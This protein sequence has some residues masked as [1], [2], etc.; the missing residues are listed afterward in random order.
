[1][2]LTEKF[3]PAQLTM[4]SWKLYEQCST[5]IGVILDNQ[6]RDP[7]I[8]VYEHVRH[9]PSEVFL[10]MEDLGGRANDLSVAYDG[11]ASEEQALVDTL[12]TAESTRRLN[13]V[14]DVGVGKTTFIKHLAALHLSTAEFCNTTPIYIDFSNFNAQLTDPIVD[15]RTKFIDTVNA[16]L[17]AMFGN[18]QMDAIDD[19]LFNSADIFSASRSIYRRLP[20][21][22]KSRF[23]AAEL[24]EATKFKGVALTIARI[25]ALCARDPNRLIIV[26]DNI[27]HLPEIVLRALSS[28]LLQIQLD[29]RPML[30]VCMRDHTFQAGFSSYREDKTVLAWNLRLKPPNL[31]MMLDRR[32]NHFFSE[33]KK[34]GRTLVTTGSGVLKIDR[35]LSKICRSLLRSPFSDQT[36]YEFI[37]RYTNYN[38]RDLFSN[39]QRIV[40]FAGFS[41]AEKE[42]LLQDEAKLK[43][44]VDECLIA[45]AL[46]DSLMFFPDRSSTFNP[47]SAG[48]DNHVLDKIVAGRV[49]QFLDYRIAAIPYSELKT[50][51]LEWGYSEIAVDAQVKAMIS[52][53][54]IWT[55]TG[56]PANFTAASE[57]SLS[58]RGK[59]YSREIVRRAVFNYMMSFD[60]EAPSDSHA[61][62]R[63][64]KSEF[65]TE[66][67]AFSD[68]GAKFDTEALAQRVM[69]MAELIY[70]SEMTEVRLLM[71]KKE[72]NDFRTAVSPRSLSLGIVDG[73]SK[74]LRKAYEEGENGWRNIPPSTAT[75][76]LV[77]E[78]SNKYRTTFSKVYPGGDPA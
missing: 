38:L 35:E 34:P 74:F 50:L 21:K 41:Y 19:A 8:T 10:H 48:Q 33:E 55:S 9:T 14:G 22:E 5:A 4:P 20:K 32:I 29:A 58:Y 39:L 62:F 44:G 64:H 18:E 15:I 37:C 45:L 51:L 36:T 57:V 71:R 25:N 1:M 7:H 6:F 72:I 59:L 75:L 67:E 27:D 63:H 28:F 66:L 65:R 16:A 42:F 49:L 13:I 2:K 60:I 46:R 17:Q 3:S 24:H 11:L 78:T 69:G 40:G 70:D 56:S 61:V 23:V 47:Y 31:R 68:F 76:R 12:R 43:I 53:D 26:I 77:G 52:K 54:L 73:L 30:V